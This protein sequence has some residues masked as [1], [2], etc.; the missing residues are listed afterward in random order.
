MARRDPDYK[1]V[2]AE[3]DYLKPY[4]DVYPEDRAYIRQLLAEERL[5]FDGRHVQRA[6]HQ[7]DERRDRRSATRSTAS[8]TSATCSAERRRP[9]GSS[10]PSATIRSSPGS[11]PTPASRR[12]RGPAGRSTSGD[13]TGYA[14]RPDADRRP[15]GRRAAADAVPDGVRLDRPERARAAD[16]LHGQPLLG[17]LVDGRGA[18]ARGGRGARSTGCSPSWRRSRR[19]R[20]CSCRSAPTTRPPNKWLTAIHRDW[21][22][23]Y[24]WP[25]FIAAIPREFFDAVRE[26][27][28][29]TRPW[30]SRRRPAT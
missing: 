19:R 6:E 14:D 16:L 25:K 22:R 17:G 2:L 21:N 9:R 11:W 23:R 7:P 26:E 27:Q 20:T 12:A 10:T 15:G 8:A 13:R 29:T 18:D 4:W 30:R 28:A 5:E 3:L 1:F 24:V